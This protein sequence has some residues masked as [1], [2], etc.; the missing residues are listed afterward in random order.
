M[1]GPLLIRLCCLIGIYWQHI[2][3]ALL[4]LAPHLIAGRW[5]SWW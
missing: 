3:A 5:W 1:T 4:R 2:E